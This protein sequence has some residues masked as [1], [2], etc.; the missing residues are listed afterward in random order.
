MHNTEIYF[1]MLALFMLTLLVALR[2]IMVRARAMRGREVDPGYFRALQ[3]DAPEYMVAAARCYGNLLELPVLFYV[4]CLALLATGIRDD[5]YL[6]LA[7][8]FVALRVA[9]ALIHLTYNNP[10]HRAPAFLLGFAVLAILWIR[11]GF[12]LMA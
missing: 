2:L 9:Q 7:W 1:P 8:V 6:I 3:G 12:R 11:L 10:R 4:V 5:L